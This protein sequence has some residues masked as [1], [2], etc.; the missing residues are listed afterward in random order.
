[1]AGADAGPT[2]RVLH[3]IDSLARGGAEQS[4][5]AMAPH[6]AAAG[7]AL[8]VAVLHDRPG[9]REELEAAGV[10]VWSLAGPGGRLGWVR[11]ARRLVAVRRPDLVHTT[12]AEASLVGRV[13][14]SSFRVPVVSSL[15]NVAYGPDQVAHGR[16]A[17]WKVRVVEALD[18]ATA[19]GVTRFHA[20]TRQ[21]AEV[22]AARLRIPRDRIDVIPRGRDPRVLGRRA[23]RRARGRAALGLD[24]REALVL[25]VGRQEP[26]KGLDVLLEAV[27]LLLEAAPTARVVVAGRDGSAT[28]ALR[29]L[30]G[31]LGI[32][33]RVAFLGA[34]ADVPDLLAACD[35]LVHPSR[36]E[37]MPGVL[38]EA[39]A[40]E[41]PVVA[42]DLPAVRELL[43]DGS[44]ATIVPV[45]DARALAGAVARTL[46]DPSG[47]AVRARRA[48][49]RFLEA[50]TVERVAGEMRSFYDRAMAARRGLA[51]AR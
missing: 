5:A 41:A 45:G 43:E 32:G 42:S 40:L 23:E 34:R 29:R 21:V 37:G 20:V 36:W 12:L 7:V 3:L 22:M 46:A 8:E 10:P 49:A 47:A 24:S 15:V 39:M 28:P 19:R 25:A 38:I 31:R 44:M 6:L 33:E 17:P 2:V 11:R 1:V 35:V 51:V 16:T 13:A 18:R 27:P 48:R 30:A 26:Q 9:L 14:A 50:F 4:L